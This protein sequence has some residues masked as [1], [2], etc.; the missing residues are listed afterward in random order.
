M[1]IPKENE[2]Q[3][4]LICIMILMKTVSICVVVWSLIQITDSDCDLS[5]SSSEDYSDDDYTNSDIEKEI[6]A[7]TNAHINR[8]LYIP[9]LVLKEY[10]VKEIMRKRT[11]K[12]VSFGENQIKEFLSEPKKRFTFDWDSDLE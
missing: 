10:R 5:S 1:R 9:Q 11:T 7:E 4:F 8:A 2:S 3:Q 6:V 12:K